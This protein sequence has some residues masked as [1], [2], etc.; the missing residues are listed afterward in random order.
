VGRALGGVAGGYR[1]ERRHAEALEAYREAARVVEKSLGAE[2][3]QLAFALVGVGQSLLDL[4]RPA[5]AL[6][7]LERAYAL[8]QR[9]EVRPREL[10]ITAF[11]LA[12]AVLAAG[13]GRER[14]LGLARRA[15]E[16]YDQ[17]GAGWADERAKIAAWLRQQEDR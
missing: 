1:A 4:G 15:L 3:P 9:G 7:P 6:E 2:H 12:R 10:G 14:A 16:L 11:F 13:G 8:R 17:A 5:E